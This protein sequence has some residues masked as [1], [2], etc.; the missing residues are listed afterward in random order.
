M[1]NSRWPLPIGTNASIHLI[2]VCNGWCTPLRVITPGATDSTGLN[3]S[4]TIG[5]LPS[6]GFPYGSTTRPI[7]ASPAGT[8]IIRPVRFTWSPS[9]ISL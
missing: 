6:N 1:I 9:L 8:P 5:P 2:P 7:K 4:V 3:L